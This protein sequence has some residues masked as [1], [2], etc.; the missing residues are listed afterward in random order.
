[1]ST[2]NTSPKR[3]IISFAKQVAPETE[4]L[5]LD[6][7]AQPSPNPPGD[8]RDL[9]N[10]IEGFV[11]GLPGVSCE[12]IVTDELIHNL[13]IT[14]KGASKGRRLVLNGHLDTFPLANKSLWTRDPLGQID[15]GKVFGLGVSDMKGGLAAALQCLKLL[16][17][18]RKYLAGELVLTFAGDEEGSG[19][20][21]MEY[22]LEHHDNTIGDAVITVD[23]GS[24]NVL[25]F[26][27]KGAIWMTVEAT[28]KPFHAAHVHLGTSAVELVIDAL[29][30][31]RSL[32][33][34]VVPTPAD[35][36]SAIASASATSEQYSGAG[37]T[38]VL[39]SV[40]VN[41][42]MV[43]G[44]HLPNV[45]AETCKANV[46][47]RLP[48]SVSV[49]DITK[50]IGKTLSKHPAVTASFSV[51]DEA[52]WTRPDAEIIKLLQSNGQDVLGDRPAITMRV[53]QSDSRLY[54]YLGVPTVVCGLTPHNM[55]A[56]DENVSRNEL[57]HL[58]EM[59]TLSAFDYLSASA[60]SDDQ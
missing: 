3:S 40:S 44:G 32:R 17:A 51:K 9:C 28:A 21:G 36:M 1:M 53:G 29:N 27:E 38:D 39:T 18:W 23:A 34:W 7:I 57:R 60:H 12:R 11:R 41:F 52:N 4:Q 26:G 19:E 46:D 8:T 20:L 59:L 13:I 31:L 43:H 22:L 24:T 47:I 30:D 2:S 37:E 58:T 55:G 35:V 42:T 50:E 16:S 25:R 15:D 10:I 45:A 14:L 56:H 6:L 48:A 54:R 49:E 33:D 5:L